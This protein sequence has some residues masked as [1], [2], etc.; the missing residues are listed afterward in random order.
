MRT[1]VVRVVM[2]VAA[3]ALLSSV[4]CTSVS[5]GAGQEAVL[6]YK[7]WVFG[8]GG[9][10]PQPVKTGRTYVA[11]STESVLVSVQPQQF[12]VHFDDLMSKDGVPLDFDAV[13]RLR[14]TDSVKLVSKFGPD[15][16]P[17]NVEAEFRNRVRQEVRT[18]GMNE[19]AID[20]TAIDAIDAAIT[21]AMVAYVK[22]AGLPIELIDITVGKANPPDS[23]KHQRIETAQQEQRIQTERQRKLAEDVRRAAEEA[24]AAADNAYRQSL[25]L[26]PDQFLQLES[27]KMQREVCA[28]G[29]CTYLL[30]S[31]VMPTLP[32][33]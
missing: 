2:G 23:V 21:E 18:H 3:A 4:A 22:T 27:I 19:T 12:T 5:P 32:V 10:E 11:M 13:I 29:K 15:W 8:H 14:V 31:G 17:A 28:G 33:R 26:S 30:G 6:I 1:R 25:Q 16:Y 20:S 24:R 7:P 9:V